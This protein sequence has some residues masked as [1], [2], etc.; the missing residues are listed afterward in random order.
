MVNDFQSC[1]GCGLQFGIEFRLP[2]VTLRFS[3]QKPCAGLQTCRALGKEASCIRKLMHHRK[4]QDKVNRFLQVVD[5]HR[6][7]SRNAGIDSLEDPSLSCPAL[8][9][10][11]HLWLD[12]YGYN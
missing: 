7:R 1:P 2:D 5:A 9:T 6:I 8:Q 3:K 4:S 12:I 11:N 10:L